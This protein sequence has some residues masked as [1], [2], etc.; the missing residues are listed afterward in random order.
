MSSLPLWYFTSDPLLAVIILTTVD[1]IGFG[2]TFRKAYK[3][4]F[5]EQLTFFM[6]IAVRN[7]ISILALENYSLTTTLFPVLTGIACLVFI[8]MVA[9]R[10]NQQH[11]NNMQS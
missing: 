3:H 8:M 1:V 4:P 9:Y 7:F 6:I 11:Q 10:R 2:P 5:E